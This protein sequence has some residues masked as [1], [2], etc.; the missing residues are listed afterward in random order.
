MKKIRAAIVGA[1]KMGG[2]H[3]KV[4]NK[5]DICDLVAVVDSDKDDRVQKLESISLY[6]IRSLSGGWGPILKAV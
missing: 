6:G 4:Y 5:L 1:G 3:A 2:I